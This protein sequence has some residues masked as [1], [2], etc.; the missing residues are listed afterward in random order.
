MLDGGLGLCEGVSG[1]EASKTSRL[2]F[3]SLL[4]LLMGETSCWWAESAGC[5]LASLVPG[6]MRRVGKIEALCRWSEWLLLDNQWRVYQVRDSP[7]G[8][9][10]RLPVVAHAMGFGVA[11]EK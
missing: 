5:I 2:I 11:F 3:A 10:G 6:V 7:R 9:L 1:S 4:K 8:D